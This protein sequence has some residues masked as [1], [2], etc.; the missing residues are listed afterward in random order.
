[1][2]VGP[3]KGFL[4]AMCN[5]QSHFSVDDSPIRTALVTARAAP[6]HARVIH[7]LRSWGVRI[8]ESMFL[9]GIPKGDFLKA[10]GADIFFD[11]QK[12]HLESATPDIATGHVIHG[13]KNDS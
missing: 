2:N 8:D 12:K 11:D 7:T 13:V 10:F 6:A 4:D 5:I 1:M 3:F 9:G